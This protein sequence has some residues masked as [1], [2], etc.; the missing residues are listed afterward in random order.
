[1]FYWRNILIWCRLIDDPD[2]TQIWEVYLIRYK[3]K[4]IGICGLYSLNRRRNELWLGNFA[5]RPEYRDK[6]IGSVVL[7]LLEKKAKQFNCTRI[8]AY[9]DKNGKRLKFYWRNGYDRISTVGTYLKKITGKGRYEKF[10]DLSDHV[11]MKEIY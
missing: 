8:Y 11:V 3:N 6:G 2:P 9:T 5:I 1:M 10:S 7:R 4:V